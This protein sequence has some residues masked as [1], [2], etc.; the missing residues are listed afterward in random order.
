[1]AAWATSPDP[2]RERR[3]KNDRDFIVSPDILLRAY[4]AGVFPMA[5]SADDPG[6]H[7]IEP[8]LRGIIPLD[9]FHLAESSRSSA[10]RPSRS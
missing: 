7:W 9:G 1:M 3:M 5:E 4:A 8:K 2:A 10:P 6:L